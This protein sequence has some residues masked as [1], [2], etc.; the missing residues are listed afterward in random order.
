V[1]EIGRIA[2]CAAQCTDIPIDVRL[3]DAQRVDHQR[4]PA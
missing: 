3:V 4:A 2:E 1:R